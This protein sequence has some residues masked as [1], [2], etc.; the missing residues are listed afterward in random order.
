MIWEIVKWVIILGQVGYVLKWA[1][2]IG[3]G[4]WIAYAVYKSGA[5]DDQM[6]A[7]RW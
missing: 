7:R 1:F 6:M 2:V 3:M 5:E 4:M